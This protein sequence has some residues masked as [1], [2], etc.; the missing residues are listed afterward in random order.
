MFIEFIRNELYVIF[1]TR[2]TGY[3]VDLCEEKGEVD[4][5]VALRHQ[6]DSLERLFQSHC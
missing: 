5:R 4:E 1:V 2:I 6:F 3:D